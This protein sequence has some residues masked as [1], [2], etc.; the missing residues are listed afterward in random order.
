MRRSRI[1][2]LQHNAPKPEREVL[3]FGEELQG[4]LGIGQKLIQID[5]STQLYLESDDK[6]N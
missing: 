1:G 4:Q 2:L 5:H 3:V 6:S